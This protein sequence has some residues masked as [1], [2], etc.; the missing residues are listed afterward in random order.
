MSRAIEFF[1][2]F[3]SA[4]A[5]PCVIQ[6]RALDASIDFKP[7]KVLMAMENVGKTPATVETGDGAITVTGD[8]AS[9]RG[10]AAFAD[11]SQQRRRN[12]SS[13]RRACGVLEAVP[14]MG[15]DR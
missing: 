1:Y 2:D 7:M 5:S 8:E 13:S 6:L 15:G 14:P 12:A 3:R 10:R 4:Y 9:Q 11:S